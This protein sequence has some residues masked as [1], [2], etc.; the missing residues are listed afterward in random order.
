M[1][2]AGLKPEDVYSLYVK[3]HAV[4]VQRQKDGYSMSTKTEDDNKSI[5]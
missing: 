3:K 4:N 5:Q 2:S 1:I